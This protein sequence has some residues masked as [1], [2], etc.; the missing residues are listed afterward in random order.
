M[1]QETSF[2]NF[3]AEIRKLQDTINAVCKDLKDIFEKE[4]GKFFSLL[5]VKGAKEGI[6]AMKT[7]VGSFVEELEDLRQFEN[8]WNEAKGKKRNEILNNKAN[9]IRKKGTRIMALASW[10]LGD[11]LSRQLFYTIY[12]PKQK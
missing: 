1:G 2:Q 8:N 12:P 9:E 6:E 7:Q 4:G 3:V 11:E 10:L 5:L